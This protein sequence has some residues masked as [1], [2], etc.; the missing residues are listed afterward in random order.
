MTTLVAVLWCVYVSDCFVR[1]SRGQWTMRRGLFRRMH[2]V[3]DPDIQLLGER[4]AFAWTPLLPWHTAFSFAGDDLNI[5]TARRRM[6][7]IDEH[8]RWLKAACAAMFAWVVVLLPV[9]VLSG[10]LLPVLWRWAAVALVFWGVTFV[11]FFRA[12]NRVHRS[13]PPFEMW[14]MMTLSPLSLI[15]APHAIGFSA[16]SDL[17]PLSAAAVLCDDDEFL[18]VARVW[19][20]DRV[21]LQGR[22]QQIVAERHLSS[23]LFSGPDGW[24]DGLSQFCPRCHATYLRAATACRDCEGIALRPLGSSS[25][26]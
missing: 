6:A 20:F 8:T 22:V 17:H 7:A 11:E 21:D 14:L 10:W 18:R 12:Y 26:A 23:R 25:P 24:D 13:R 15:R 5:K 19:Y 2:G 16:V 9:L 1:Q 4:F 3:A